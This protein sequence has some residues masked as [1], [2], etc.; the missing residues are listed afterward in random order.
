MKLSELKNRK[1]LP[2]RD[3][4]AFQWIKP[5][6]VSKFIIPETYYDLKPEPGYSDG[7]RVGRFYLGRVLAV[8]RKVKEIKKN[9]I[10]MV[11]EYG[12]KNYEGAWNSDF[13]Y[14]IEENQCSMKVDKV[15]EK[16]YFDFRKKISKTEVAEI[17]KGQESGGSATGIPADR[18]ERKMKA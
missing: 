3:L 10:L 14:F 9:D 1:I 8:G 18:L 15:P 7:L 12:I 17:L 16:G 2:L 4:I 6:L 13:I 11:H 5:H